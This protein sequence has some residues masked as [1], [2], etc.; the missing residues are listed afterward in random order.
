[1]DLEN[2]FRLLFSSSFLEFATQ[3]D[4]GLK[5]QTMG[6]YALNYFPFNVVVSELYLNLAKF[7]HSIIIGLHFLHIQIHSYII[8][9]KYL[10]PKCLYLCSKKVVYLH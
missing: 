4:F 9:H 1:M 6:Q 10:L 8:I 5:I 3:T 7:A 2:F